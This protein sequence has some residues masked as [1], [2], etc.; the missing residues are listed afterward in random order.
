MSG[1][2]EQEGVRPA[3]QFHRK[4]RGKRAGRERQEA[5]KARSGQDVSTRPRS[6]QDVSPRDRRRH[7]GMSFFLRDAGGTRHDEITSITQDMVLDE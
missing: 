5:A 1:D 4:K 6:G 3:Q 7:V 2:A